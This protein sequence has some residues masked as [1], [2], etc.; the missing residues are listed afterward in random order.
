MGLAEMKTDILTSRRDKNIYE[1]N[2]IIIRNFH[3]H[4]GPR[5]FGIGLMGTAHGQIFLTSANGN[6]SEYSTAGDLINAAFVSGL[7]LPGPITSDGNGNLYVILGQSAFSKYTTSGSLVYNYPN[8]GGS[9]ITPVGIAFSGGNLY[10]PDYGDESLKLF[11]AATGNGGNVVESG[12][13][14]LTGGVVA[15]GNDWFVTIHGGGGPTDGKIIGS[16]GVFASGLNEPNGLALDGQ[17]NIF[18]A[19]YGSDTIAEYTTAGQLVNPSLISG[20]NGPIGL[21]TDGEGHL[22]V[23]ENGSI[24]EFTTSG[25]TVNTNLISGL[26]DFSGWITVVPEPSSIVLGLFGAAFA[27]RRWLSGISKAGKSVG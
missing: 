3:R 4:C 6:I 12:V 15:S 26:S 2:K 10:I 22:F 16:K 8:Q 18:V 24:G 5:G 1:N 27:G 7:S 9:L 20:L 23:G 14:D 25:Q 21:A 11:D 17:G 19:N 13:P